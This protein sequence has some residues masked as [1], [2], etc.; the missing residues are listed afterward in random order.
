MNSMTKSGSRIVFKLLVIAAIFMGTIV[1]TNV[2]NAG[3]IFPS[4]IPALGLLLEENID[5]AASVDVAIT[6]S[7]PDQL[8]DPY[9]SKSL[10]CSSMEDKI[11]DEAVLVQITQHFPVCAVDPSIACISEVWA[12]HSSGKKN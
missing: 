12:I 8:N 5:I 7:D 10:V 2:A 11:C 6:M 4:N 3:A 9:Q 1:Q